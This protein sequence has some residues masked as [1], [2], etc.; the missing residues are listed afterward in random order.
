M[1]TIMKALR[2][3][4]DQKKTEA[5]ASQPGELERQIVQDVELPRRNPPKRVAVIVGAVVLSGLA[6]VG[7]TLGALSLWQANGD[8]VATAS[9]ALAVS[10]AGQAAVVAAPDERNEGTTVVVAQDV[11]NSINNSNNKNSNARA[12]GVEIVAGSQNGKDVIVVNA[13]SAGEATGDASATTPP[14]TEPVPMRIIEAPA[15]IARLKARREERFSRMPRKTAQAA[16]ATPSGEEP[17]ANIATAT[18]DATPARAPVVAVNIPDETTDTIARHQRAETKAIEDEL[19][20]VTPALIDVAEPQN[21]VREEVGAVQPHVVSSVISKVDEQMID[22]DVSQD[23]HRVVV[24]SADNEVVEAEVEAEES[25][26]DDVMSPASSLPKANTNA[27]PRF[28]ISGTTWH[29]YRQRRTAD[30]SVETAGGTRTV[31]VREGEMLGP[32]KV[33]E[34]GPTSITFLHEG[35][36]IKR[37][38]GAGLR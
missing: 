35:K 30:I 22:R 10:A 20:A 3:V 34:I 33:S 37:R 25:V 14:V 28:A 21:I 16:T 5:H 11:L 18:A 24:E 9:E 31:E 4:E 8:G 38:I 23:S 13:A 36:V 7:I 17:I 32:M 26:S 27:V 1:S 6:G 15:A 29:P 12:G 19:A 2:K